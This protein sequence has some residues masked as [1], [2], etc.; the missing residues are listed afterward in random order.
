[1]SAIIYPLSFYPEI[2]GY[3]EEIAAGFDET[4][5]EE[6]PPRRD[7]RDPRGDILSCVVW[8][9]TA[10]SAR[11][12]TFYRTTLKGGVRTFQAPH[13][14]TRA[15][16]GMAFLPDGLARG[17]KSAVWQQWQLRLRVMI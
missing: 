7:A 13:P 10:D 5:M 8:Y 17:L 2:S 1:M 4:E 11:L 12:L 6:G 16:V 15:L 9:N 14:I 3:T